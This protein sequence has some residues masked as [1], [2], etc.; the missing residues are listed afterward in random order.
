MKTKSENPKH[1]P[2]ARRKRPTIIETKG[3]LSL[4][5]DGS[6]LTRV[7]HV[8]ERAKRNKYRREAAE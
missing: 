2:L 1:N 7:R 4:R 8:N 5:S 6:I 3:V